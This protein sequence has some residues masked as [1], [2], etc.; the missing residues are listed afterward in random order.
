MQRRLLGLIPAALAL[1]WIS[2]WELIRHWVFEKVIHEAEGSWRWE[3]L[4]EYGPIVVFAGL[5]LWLLWP[6]IEERVPLPWKMKVPF[7]E[8]AQSLY[9]AA[10][11]ADALEF[12][13]LQGDQS[14]TM[15]NHFRYVLTCADEVTLHGRRPPSRNW[16]PIPQDER[17]SLHPVDGQPNA[18]GNA[19]G[20]EARY[21]DVYVTRKDLRRR[22]KEYIDAARAQ[23]TR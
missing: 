22:M 11:K 9:E 12:A 3:W 2:F 5:A 4:P 19:L 6:E 14:D 21:V 15:L 7:E 18:L 20:R 10:E 8:A 23:S 13:Q 16:L 1:F 17:R